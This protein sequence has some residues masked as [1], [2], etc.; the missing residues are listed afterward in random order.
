MPICENFEFFEVTHPGRLIQNTVHFEILIVGYDNKL[1]YFYQNSVG[2]SKCHKKW[3]KNVK[4]IKTLT[5]IFQKKHFT[6]LT[7]DLILM[8]LLTLLAIL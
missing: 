5:I 6:W 1:E 3:R 2:F 8:G 4:N 7:G